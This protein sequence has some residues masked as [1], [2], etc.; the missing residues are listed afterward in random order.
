MSLD[1]SQLEKLPPEHRYRDY[2]NFGLGMVK[3]LVTFCDRWK[4]RPDAVW[5]LSAFSLLVSGFFFLCY[6]LFLGFFFLLAKVAITHVGNI[7]ARISTP[8][9]AAGYYLHRILEF[10]GVSFVLYCI[11]QNAFEFVPG[12]LFLALAASTFLQTTYFEYYETH[13]LNALDI[14]VYPFPQD[15]VNHVNSPRWMHYLRKAE[16]YCY[17]WQARTVRKL[18]IWMRKGMGVPE[19]WYTD[20]TLLTRQTALRRGLQLGSLAVLSLPLGIAMATTVYLLGSN[21]YWAWLI[22]T[23]RQKA[24]SPQSTPPVAQ[25]V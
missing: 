2:G 20:K 10:V 6:D 19:G 12:L 15:D 16:E 22:R 8:P 13:Y 23:R 3:P 9:S 21:L 1:W 17:T 24:Q 25:S 5:L 11:S 14:H 7:V 4:I 18:D